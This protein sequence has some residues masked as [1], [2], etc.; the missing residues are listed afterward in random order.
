MGCGTAYDPEELNE[1]KLALE[2]TV[3]RTLVCAAR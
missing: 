3:K 2:L 1:V